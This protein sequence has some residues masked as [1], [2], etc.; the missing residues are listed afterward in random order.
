MKKLIIFTILA[1]SSS[2]FAQ[3]GS[4][5]IL[6]G[7]IKKE[8]LTKSP[9]NKWFNGEYEKYEIDKNVLASLKGI[10]W[11]D[12]SFDLFM[13]TWCGDTQREVPRMIKVLDKIG[14]YPDE[15]NIIALNTGEGVHKQSPTGE[16]KDKYI[17]RVPTFIIY[18]KGKEIGRIVE[19]PV[20][21]LERDLITIILPHVVTPS[22][23]KMVSDLPSYSPNYRSYPYIINWIKKGTLS[24]KNVSVQGLAEQIRFVTRSAGEITGAAYTL[25]NAGSTK[26]AAV[27]CK[28]AATLYPDT[29]NYYTCSQIFAKNGEKDAA[30]SALTNYLSKT[31]DKGNIEAALKLYDKI[32]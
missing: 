10:D 14:F 17:F 3:T 21:S 18:N 32:K 26:E 30:M 19:H 20:E 6:L 22:D 4:N 9:Y 16:E 29:V 1:F 15:Y 24:D 5:P 7:K 2:L 28:I 27:L 12:I 13:G 11:T 25:V 23:P 31:T 8:D